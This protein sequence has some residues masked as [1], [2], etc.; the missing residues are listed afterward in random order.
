MFFFF[1]TEVMLLKEK[2]K[3]N[4]LNGTIAKW[5]S[6]WNFTKFYVL[7]FLLKWNKHKDTIME[8]KKKKEEES[9]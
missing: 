6:T 2:S 4:K 3:K 7:Y 5:E 9:I 8:K 1:Y